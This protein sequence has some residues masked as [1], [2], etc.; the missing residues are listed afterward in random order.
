MF[1]DHLLNARYCPAAATTAE[2]AVAKIDTVPA[3]EAAGSVEEIEAAHPFVCLV[4]RNCGS[5]FSGNTR[6]GVPGF[7][8][9]KSV[10]F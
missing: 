6:I 8:T 2:T 7:A 4:A 3:L 9:T 5:V 1:V 10:S